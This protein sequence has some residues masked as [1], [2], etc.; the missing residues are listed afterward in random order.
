MVEV[1]EEGW[2][3]VVVGTEEEGE[4]RKDAKAL[5]APDADGDTA[6]GGAP[7][8]QSPVLTSKHI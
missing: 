5:V 4:D 3:V 2:P 6:N 7:A 1:E 8:P